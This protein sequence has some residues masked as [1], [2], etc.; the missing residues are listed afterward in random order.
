MNEIEEVFFHALYD[1]L[2]EPQD[3]DYEFVVEEGYIEVNHSPSKYN[4]IIDS[5]VPQAPIEIY[6]A[7]F[8]IKAPWYPMYYLPDYIVEIDGHEAHKTKQQRHDDYERERFLMKKGYKVIRFTGSEVYVDAR[9]CA[10]ETIKIIT[11]G[12]RRIIDNHEEYRRDYLEYISACI[13]NRK[14]KKEIMDFMKNL[15]GK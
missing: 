14:S 4:N 1:E 13:F 8:L 15:I 3:R 6:F 5:V 9:R 2:F 10:S 7:D 11:S 12:A